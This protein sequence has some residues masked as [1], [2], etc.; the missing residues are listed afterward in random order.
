VIRII[1]IFF[2]GFVCHFSKPSPFRNRLLEVLI[3]S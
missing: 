1:I 3:L 2:K